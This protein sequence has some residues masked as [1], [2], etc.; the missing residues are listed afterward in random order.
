MPAKPLLFATHNKHKLAEV[1]QLI[2]S[3][4][5]VIGL[6]DIGFHHD[7]PEPYDTFIDNA[8]AKTTFLFQQTGLICFAEDSG[9]EVDALQ[10]RPG[11]YSARYAGDHRGPE[12]NIRKVL[13][14]LGSTQNRSARFIA[15]MAFRSSKDEVHFFKG[16]VEGSISTSPRGKNGFGY[17]PIFIPNGFDQTF[18]ELSVAIKNRIS[19]R[20]KALDKFLE[21]LSGY[22]QS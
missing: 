19:H 12:D 9:L 16:T 1:R 21:F 4:F 15:L 5:E 14:E 6:D 17:D 18:G 22:R 13:D 2:P 3:Q 7:I 8:R 20:R 10:G 11:V